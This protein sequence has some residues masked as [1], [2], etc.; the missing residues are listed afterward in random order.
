MRNKTWI[1]IL[2]VFS[3]LLVNAQDD[4]IQKIK[5]NKSE[6]VE[7]VFTPICQI[8]STSIKDQGSSGTCW[9]YSTNSFL[10][11]EILR[12]KKESID[13]SE[14]YTVRNMYIDKAE[15]YVRMHG[16]LAYGQGGAF[17]DV[18]NMYRRY[19]ALPQDVYQGL[20]Y[21]TSRNNHEE[22]ETVLKGM[23]DAIIK[24]KKLTPIW[25]VAVTKVVDTYLGAVPEKFNYKG[26]EY[27]PKSWA[28]EVVGINPDDYLEFTSFSHAP[29]YQKMLVMVPDNWSYDLSYNVKVGEMTEIM[30][31]ALKNGYSIAWATDVSDKGFSWKNGV[32]VVPQK[33]FEDMDEKEKSS[34]FSTSIPEKSITQELRQ[35]EFDNYLTTDDHGMHLT[36]LAKDQFG[37]EYYI[38]KNSWGEKNDYKGFLYVSKPFVELKTTTFIVHK[39]GVPKH[40]LKKLG[41]N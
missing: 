24:G 6:K 16:S 31:H 15:S 17:H 18:L 41:L 4:L 25:K 22:L 1:F 28:S 8:S 33:S 36:G 13:I 26:K 14:M 2:L 27:T 39:N 7:I 32:A 10:E 21:G 34:V 23:L 12:N 35:T 11:S 37:K 5:D 40:I 38:T 9:C 19:G 29:F 3:T 30:D 20:N